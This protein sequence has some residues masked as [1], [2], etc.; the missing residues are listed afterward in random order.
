[1]KK[2]ITIILIVISV[3]AGFAQEFPEPMQPPRMVNDFSELLNSNEK[4]SLEAK[5]QEFYYQTSNQIYVVI[6]DDI[7]GYDISDYSF[8]L[9]EKWGIG[10]K[11]KDN[12]ILILL[13]P[14]P[15]R[16]HGDVFIASGYGLEG[17]VPDA[18]TKRIVEFDMIPHFKELDYYGG[19]N[20]AT[21][22]IM[23]LTRGEYTMDEYIQQKSQGSSPGAGIFTLFFMIFIFSML[24]RS[25]SRRHHSVGRSLP[26]WAA[27]FMAS[28]AGRSHGGS[29]GNFSSGSG[30]FGGGGFGGGMGG[31]F[32]GGGAGGSW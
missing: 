7:S 17:A 8:Q 14:S 16:K 6:M 31:S 32:G 26:F 11:G 23:D 21:S 18:H 12:G 10:T 3:S 27:L 19:L 9:G 30:G 28:G 22:T 20:A 4:Q 5:L 24:G 1:M 2:I 29:F 15:D 25:R 13:N